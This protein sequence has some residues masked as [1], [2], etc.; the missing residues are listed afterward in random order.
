MSWLKPSDI[1]EKLSSH[2]TSTFVFPVKVRGIVI[3]QKGYYKLTDGEAGITLNVPPSMELPVG[4]EVE[5]EGV[6]CANPFVKGDVA[7]IY[8][9]INVNSYKVLDEDKEREFQK[10]LTEVEALLR[11]RNHYGFWDTFTKLLGE[12]GRIKIGLIHGNS[13][14]VW[15]DFIIGFRSAA[16]KYADRGR[17]CEV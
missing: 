8:P 14:Q 1:V 9:A 12:R 3:F 5:I 15:Q 6:I 13:A 4:A 11:N 16:G 17:V 10:K 2:I 7:M